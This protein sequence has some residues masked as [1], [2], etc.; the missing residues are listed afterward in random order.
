MLYRI[1]SNKYHIINIPRMIWLN[2]KIYNSSCVILLTTKAYFKTYRY[3][4]TGYIHV[5]V[6]V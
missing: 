5:Y 2:C 3:M 4:S 6:S 1:V